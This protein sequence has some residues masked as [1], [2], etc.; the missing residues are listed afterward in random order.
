VH[1]DILIA[2]GMRNGGLPVESKG[3]DDTDEMYRIKG[4]RD[5]GLEAA[6]SS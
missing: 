3:L 2:D 4:L 6:R 1:R 5:M